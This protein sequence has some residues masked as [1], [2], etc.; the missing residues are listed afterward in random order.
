MTLV[1]IVVPV[2]QNAASLPDLAARFRAVA[3]SCSPR[4]F[5]FLFVDDGS[6]D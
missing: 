2:Y 6:R 4:Q 3:E 1:T 5:E